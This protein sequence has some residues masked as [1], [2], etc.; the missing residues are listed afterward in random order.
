MDGGDWKRAAWQPLKR[1][2]W[3]P[4]KRAWQPL[5]RSDDENPK[6]QILLSDQEGLEEALLETVEDRIRQ[7]LQAAQ[8]YGLSPEL[9]LSH[10]RS[11]SEAIQTQSEPDAKS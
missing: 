6:F 7:D 1:A 5:K 9:I 11:K 10:L 8:N 3:Q 2:A 4:L